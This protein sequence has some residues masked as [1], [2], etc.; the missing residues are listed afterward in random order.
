M[1]PSDIGQGSDELWGQYKL[2]N[3]NVMPNPGVWESAASEKIESAF[4]P[5]QSCNGRPVFMMGWA[6]FA[7]RRG[8]ARQNKG[9]GR[10]SAG[11]VGRPMMSQ[12]RCTQV[13]IRN[14]L[15]DDQA[16]R[17]VDGKAGGRGLVLY[18]TYWHLNSSTLNWEVQD[19][20]VG[21]ELPVQHSATDDLM[22]RVTFRSGGHR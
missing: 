9:G 10:V 20:Q 2:V 14:G 17:Y 12:F 3:A 16:G 18:N 15:D 1:G 22:K 19:G 8:Q 21:A 5:M 7:W 13:I 6:L 11:A 4:E